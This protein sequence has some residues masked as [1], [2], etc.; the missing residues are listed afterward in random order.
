[1]RKRETVQRKR[2]KGGG[3]VAWHVS[4][5][6]LEHPRAGPRLCMLY[7]VW[8]GSPTRARV[9]HVAGWVARDRDGGT[10]PLHQREGCVLG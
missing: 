9:P 5:V 3:E 10:T 8:V 7:Q 2:A 1:V 4:D 6:T